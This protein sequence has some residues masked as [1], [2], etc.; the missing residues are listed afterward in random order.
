MTSNPTAY[1]AQ[2]ALLWLA[3]LC[4]ACS[5][6]DLNPIIEEPEQRVFDNKLK[7]SGE[8]CTDDPDQLE[9]PLK[10]L[11]V[12]DTSSSMQIS[13]PKRTAPDP[14]LGESTLVD[15]TQSTGRS[16]AV[17]QVISQFIDLRVEFPPVYCD[18]GIAGC[19]PAETGCSDCAGIGTAA[20]CVGP[21]CTG[22]K[23]GTCLPL[24]DATIAGCG[25]QDTPPCP[26]CPNSTSRCI[27]GVC[28]KLLDPG[29][30]FG[31]IRFGANAQP[32]TRN[33]DGVEGFT[34]DPSQLVTALPQ[35]ANSNGVT[36]YEAVLDR[37][38]QMLRDDIRLMRDTKAGALTRTK[39]AIIFLT[40]GRPDPQIN[41]SEDW[42]SL[43]P[44]I[45]S[46]ML[47]GTGA[48]PAQF[49][50][51]NIAG[52]ILRRVNELIGLKALHGLGD[53]TLHTAL[54]TDPLQPPHRRDQAIALL[55][56][57]RRVGD[58]TF[59]N[60]PNGEEINF[61]HVDFSRLNRI[62][63]LKNFIVANLNARPRGLATLTD[64]DADGLD[65]ETEERAGTFIAALDTDGDG[66]SDTLEHFFRQSGA[67]PLDPQDADCTLSTNDSDGDGRPDDS[68]GDGLLDCEER[69]MGTNRNLFDSDA[70]G[71]PDNLEVRFGTNPVANDV[72]D[73]LDFDGMPNGDELRLHTDPN[74]DDAA[75]RSRFSYRYD[76]KRVG[77]GIEKEPMSCAEDADCPAGIDCVD[78][79]CRCVDATDC[80]TGSSCSTDADCTRPGET[81]KGGANPG[82]P[83]SC[84]S[85][86][87]CE[88]HEDIKGDALTCTVSRN[89]TCYNYTVENIALV[90]PRGLSEEGWNTIHLYFGE[91]P[92]DA[93]EDFGVFKL[94]CVRARY[95][96]ETG[97]KLPVNGSLSVPQSIFKSP[98]EFDP[99]TDCL[100]PD[101]TLGDCLQ[102]P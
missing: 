66:F 96:E 79:F 24:C 70:D 84:Q 76:V 34:N 51:Y 11:F 27:S 29:V 78:S 56:Q 13:D 17:K 62:F 46:A 77:T 90:Q 26:Q 19:G 102:Q 82:D 87:S 65:D 97:A 86:T 89:I 4:P 36:N 31:I 93:P 16:R 61:L 99:S 6:R 32:L 59:R 57:M 47:S 92:F 64:S 67:D 2:I 63:Q 10:V 101:G 81:C 94:G 69:F 50:Q 74:E 95:S 52:R 12:I 83:L 22:T 41:G 44:E 37:A 3:L 43:A 15:P 33:V 14:A 42:E 9:F 48:S 35:L 23:C 98:A 54:L 53:V 55:Q 39:Y 60:F 21:D 8:I 20:T 38:L 85:K 71:V 18:T 1:K 25:P 88:K 68:D 91:A 73:D 28:S 40:D 45:A 30:E 75:H 100:C 80:S 72:L 7:L 58:G 49:Q 5:K